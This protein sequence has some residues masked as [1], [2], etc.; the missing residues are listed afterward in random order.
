[1]S[2]GFEPGFGAALAAAREAKGLSRA[3]V[4][5]RLKLSPRQIEALE[6][7]DWTALPSPVFV[8]GFVRNY[9]RLLELDPERLI[10][11][12]N[13]A[14]TVTRTITAPS[15]GVRLGGSPVARWLVLPLVLAVLFV[16]V[17]AGLYTWLRQGEQ[18]LVAPAQPPLQGEGQSGPQTPAATG[19]PALTGEASAMQPAPAQP[20]ADAQATGP[21][22]Q[23]PPP[24]TEPVRPPG[25]GPVPAAGTQPATTVPGV[26]TM[27]TNSQISPAADKEPA[28]GQVSMRFLPAEDAWIQVVDGKGMRF[29]KLVRAGH[30]EVVSGTP[31]FKL[32]VGNAAHVSLVYNGHVIDLKPFIGEKVARL[33]L[34]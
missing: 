7:E 32:V 26:A 5:E 6:A 22:T 27:T 25:Q 2:R 13:G 9:A 29:S 30:T 10:A 4:A 11:P 28:R 19:T 31:P 18:V 16:T 34:E 14:E 8:R 23:H 3:E 20:V 21:A 15:A 17:V 1:M 33:T 12:V 24:A